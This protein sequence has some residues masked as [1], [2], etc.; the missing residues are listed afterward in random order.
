[1][2]AGRGKAEASSSGG[3][4]PGRCWFLVWSCPR[5]ARGTARRSGLRSWGMKQLRDRVDRVAASEAKMSATKTGDPV[6]RVIGDPRLPRI[7]AR[8]STP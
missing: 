4:R 8:G 7:L 3:E 6:S 5:A 2:T 1:M